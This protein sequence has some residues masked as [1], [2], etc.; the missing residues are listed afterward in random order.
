MISFFQKKN[1]I[2]LFIISSLHLTKMKSNNMVNKKIVIFA[3]SKF[4]N[5]FL[6]L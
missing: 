1:F 2:L 4:V 6:K 3:I 5:A